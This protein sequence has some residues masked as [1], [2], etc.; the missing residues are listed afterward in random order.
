MMREEQLDAVAYQL[1]FQ[2]SDTL[3]MIR[4]P[5]PVSQ[6]K[7]YAGCLKRNSCYLNKNLK[8][9]VVNDSLYAKQICEQFLL[10]CL[11]LS[12][13]ALAYKALN[14]G[15]VDAY[16]MQQSPHLAAPCLQGIGIEVHP[17]ANTQINIYH[18]ISKPH[19]NIAQ[20]LAERLKQLKRDFKETSAQECNEMLNESRF[21]D[22][23]ALLR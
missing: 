12:T 8:F 23:L 7:L 17:I 22:G 19:S 20:P 18:F 2:A 6:F 11:L 10:Q 4:V 14:E 15:I 16:I 21:L 3:G 9:V 1:N 5:E 13:P